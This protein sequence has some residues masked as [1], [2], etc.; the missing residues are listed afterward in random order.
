[1]TLTH[2]LDAVKQRMGTHLAVRPVPSFSDA[3]LKVISTVQ[4]TVFHDIYDGKS[5]SYSSLCPFV[6]ND[7][8]RVGGRLALSNLEYCNKFPL[9]IPNDHPFTLALIKHYHHQVKHQGRVITLSAIREAGFYIPKASSTVRKIVREC[10]EC[11]RLRLPLA[12]QKMSDLPKDRL[13]CAPPFTYTGMDV[14][15]PYIVSDGVNTRRTNSNKKCWALIFTCLNS[16]A[17]HIE[18]LPFL[19]TSTLKNAIRRFFCV[20]GVSKKLRSDHGTNFIGVKNQDEN[21][22]VN[23]TDIIRD[24]ETQGCEWELTP[25]KASHHGG[26]WE[27]QIKTVKSILM[28][29]LYQLGSKSLTRDD[30]YTFLQECASIMNSTPLWEYSSDPNDPRPLSPS[31]LLT[32]RTD[33]PFLPEIYQTKDLLAYGSKRWRRVQFLSEQFWFRWRRDYLQSLH[34]RRKLPTEQRSFKVGDVVLLKDRSVKSAMNGQ[35]LELLELRPV[36]TD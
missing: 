7:L 19:D 32:L 28:T 33:S 11:R 26:V 9:L 27:R 8:I 34:V 22:L 14:F 18:P 1:M 15:G 12:V 10:V 5:N 30:F 2:K 31:M 13:Q 21:S 6:N 29:C 16:R 36:L 24:V 20:R 23:T 25:P 35:L 17:T 3:L 4:H